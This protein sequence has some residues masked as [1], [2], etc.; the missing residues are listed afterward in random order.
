LIAAE[1]VDSLT[2]PELQQ[3]CQARGV[4]TIGASPARLRSELTQWIDLH[5]NQKIPS[6]LLLLSRAFAISERVPTDPQQALQG[7]AQA[8]QA[9]LSS[10][11]D[12][13]VNEAALEVAEAEG[14][15][16]YKQ[17]LNVLQEQEEL[18]ADELEQ[19]AVKVG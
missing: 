17:K 16:T 7:S 5:L 15:A 9:T 11:P 10:L 1:G 6:S 19:E 12:Q 13:V 8:L 3:A 2:V 4:R 14:V 18:I